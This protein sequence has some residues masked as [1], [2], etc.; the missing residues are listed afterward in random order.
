MIAGAIHT[1]VTD[2]R[3]ASRHADLFLTE[4]GRPVTYQRMQGA[5]RQISNAL[6][7]R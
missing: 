1:Y 7:A 6:E 4:E 2:H 3:R 5:P